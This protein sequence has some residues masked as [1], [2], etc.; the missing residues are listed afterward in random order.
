MLRDE[1]QIALDDVIEACV[2][3]TEIHRQGGELLGASE[4]AEA[5]Q[6]LA[7]ERS[8]AAEGL[9]EHLRAG[10]AMPKE[11]DPEREAARDMLVR[12]Q[13]EMADDPRAEVLERCYEAEGALVEAVRAALACDLTPE[14]RGRLERLL[15]DDHREAGRPAGWP[16]Q[17]R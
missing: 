11:P 6:S 1:W 16:R 12:A 8:L 3:A 9:I 14:V 10:G 5:L 13:V 17:S 15:T 4:D 7:R 2:H